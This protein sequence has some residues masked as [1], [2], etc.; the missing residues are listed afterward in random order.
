MPYGPEKRCWGCDSSRQPKE[1]AVIGRFLLSFTFCLYSAPKLVV[2]SAFTI[3]F[4]YRKALKPLGGSTTSFSALNF[5][6]LFA[7]MS[8]PTAAT[9]ITPLMICW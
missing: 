4:A 7:L 6:Y 9:S 2:F 1:A 3:H 5:A 8:N